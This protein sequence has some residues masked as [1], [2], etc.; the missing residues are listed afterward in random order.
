[1]F[2]DSLPTIDFEETYSEEDNLYPRETGNQNTS[3]E[4]LRKQ[5][6]LIKREQPNEAGFQGYGQS[7]ME[8]TA[9][10]AKFPV[11]MRYV[12]SFSKRVTYPVPGS[13]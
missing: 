5:R 8:A 3:D 9:P 1:M 2:N 4:A 13:I 7:W 11:H 6:P 12:F 10:I